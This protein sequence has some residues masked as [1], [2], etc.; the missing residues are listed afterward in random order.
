[1]DHT[2]PATTVHH[3]TPI[4]TLTLAAT[5]LGLVSSSFTIPNKIS[6][7]LS[8][9]TGTDSPAAQAWL[10]RTRTEL[11]QYFAGDLRTFTVP[12]D[13]RLAGSFDRS[14]LTALTNVPH[15]TTTSYGR[16]GAALGLPRE[17]IRK[18]GQA[19]SRNPILIV[20]PCH[21]VIGADGTLTGYAAGLPAKRRLLDLE[22]NQHQL[23]LNL[24]A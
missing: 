23:N 1:M 14:V 15:G 21:R 17:D 12:L 13:L 7:R 11:D 9:L 24:S 6:T 18:V 16:L 20:I 19:L 2:A 5:E 8:A 4:G 22:G 10:N 3:E